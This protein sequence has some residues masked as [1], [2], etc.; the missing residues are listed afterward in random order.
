MRDVKNAFDLHGLQ[1]D[2]AKQDGGTPSH[3]TYSK[4]LTRRLRARSLLALWRCRLHA[5]HCLSITVTASSIREY[6]KPRSGQGGTSFYMF[7]HAYLSIYLQNDSTVPCDAVVG[8]WFIA[9]PYCALRRDALART[10]NFTTS[11]GFGLSPSIVEVFP[12]RFSTDLEICCSRISSPFC[13]ARSSTCC[14][15]PASLPTHTPKLRV[16]SPGTRR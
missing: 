9:N 1:G 2:I 13:C 4:I 6:L 10:S 11:S 12:S 15:I 8:Y 16:A 7:L 5:L 14:G 3:D